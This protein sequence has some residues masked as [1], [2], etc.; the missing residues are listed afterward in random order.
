MFE[1]EIKFIYDFNLNKVNKLGPYF[2][3]EQLQSVDLHPAILNYISAEIDFLVF[4]DRQKLL[5]NSVFDYSGEKIASFF[6]EINKE[7]K[8]SKRFS[9]EYI[10]KLILHAASFTVNYLVRPKWTLTR[11]VFD[12]AKHKSTNEIKQILNYVYYYKFVKKIIIS[13]IN[14]KKILSMNAEEFEELLKRTDKLGM[15]SNL[16]GIMSSSLISM[17]EFFNI[18]QMQKTRIPLS[19]VELFLE[20][21][22]LPLHIQKIANTLGTDENAHFYIGDYMKAITSIMPV[23]KEEEPLQQDLFLFEEQAIAPE[24]EPKADQDSFF[25]EYNDTNDEIAASQKDVEDKEEVSAWISAEHKAENTELIPFVDEEVTIKPNAKIRIK[26][27]E[28]NKIEPVTEEESIEIITASLTEESL[29]SYSSVIKGFDNEEEVI[30]KTNSD[31]SDKENTLLEIVEDIEKEAEETEEQELFFGQTNS[32]FIHEVEDEKH[33]EIRSKEVDQ[34]FVEESQ[35]EDELIQKRFE[36]QT[37]LE[38]SEI[39]EHKNI[40]K[41]IEVVFD[42]DIED[43]ANMLDEISSCKNVDDAHFIINETLA[44]RRINRNSK[45]AEILRDIISEYFDRR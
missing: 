21:K 31:E 45:E 1:R 17:A 7:L 37:T 4:E 41:I 9:L 38:L 22:D 15:E 19:A 10:A 39:L 26:V 23:L 25:E 2:T 18:G 14:T 35:E 5:K 42:Y 34:A 33:Y 20:E 6:T 29:D 8:K 36:E 44:I 3:F 16:K 30:E 27:N 28:G 11:F 43:F 24:T 40:T 13:Y 12:E 32:A